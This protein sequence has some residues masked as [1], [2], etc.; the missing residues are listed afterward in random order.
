MSLSQMKKVEPIRDREWVFPWGKWRGTSLD[1]VITD[2]PDYILWLQ[3]NTDMDFHADIIDEC[4]R[5]EYW[6]GQD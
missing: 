4:K 1:E 6:T 3:S 2:D 5:V